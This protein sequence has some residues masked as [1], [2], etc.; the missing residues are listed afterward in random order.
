MS[1][2]GNSSSQLQVSFLI[3]ADDT[4]FKSTLLRDSQG[5]GNLSRKVA[6]SV[7]SLSVEGV[8]LVNLT[9]PVVIEFKVNE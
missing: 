1:I 3:Y 7:V 6:G 4:L 2:K 5:P 9:E 8:D